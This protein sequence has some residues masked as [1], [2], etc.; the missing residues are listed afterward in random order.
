MS[1]SFLQRIDLPGE[2]HVVAD[3]LPGRAPAYVYLHG[4]ASVRHGEKSEALLRRARA[5][6]REFLR[7][8]FPGHGES[9][10]T[11]GHVTIS[12]LVRATLRVLEQLPHRALLVGSSL[13]GL[14]ASLIAARHPGAVHGLVLIAPAFGF[15]PRM[16]A[17]PRDADYVVVTSQWTEV[18]LHRRVLDDA[19]T[20]GEETLAERIHV[21]TL[22]VHGE[23]DATVPVRHSEEFHARLAARRKELWVVPGGDHRLN[24]QI[25]AILDRVEE[26]FP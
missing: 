8:D 2:G 14:V 22:V 5:R 6:G 13:G 20:L 23:H 12:E 26:F 16:A 15:L 3:R 9:S 7:F 1:D 11:M 21:P 18:R 4:L 17:H 24:E 10:G 25:E 19:A